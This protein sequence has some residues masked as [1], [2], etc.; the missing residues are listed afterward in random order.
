MDKIGIIIL[1]AGESSRLGQPKQLLPFG[2]KTLLAHIADQALEANLEPVIVVTGAYAPEVVDSLSDR[3]VIIAHNPHPL[4]G[5]HG[6]RHRRGAGGIAVGATPYLR[7]AIIAVCDQPHLS[8]SLLGELVEQ[9]RMSKKGLVA[10]AYG[11]TLG[12]PVLFGYRYFRVLSALS[13]AEGAKK[14]LK[15]YP[16]DVATVSFPGGEIDI[17]TGEDVKN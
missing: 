14:L 16:D 7:G 2:G 5:R 15:A 3:P 11:D 17:D 1:A 12:T 6:L 13:G 10:C 9:F 8:A 4:G